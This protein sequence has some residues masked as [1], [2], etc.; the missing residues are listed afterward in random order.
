MI[1]KKIITISLILAW[2]GIFAIIG[3]GLNQHTPSAS[4]APTTTT[5]LS[6]TAKT[7]DL[8]TDGSAV[9]Q[10][11]ATP[12]QSTANQTALTPTGTNS[13]PQTPS[14]TATGTGSTSAT[15]ATSANGATGGTSTGGGTTGGSTGSTGGGTG[16]TGGTTPTPAPSISSFAASPSSVSYNTGSTL[17]WASS[18]ATGCSISPTVGSVAASGSRSTGNLASNTTYTLTCTGNGSASK[19]TTVSVGAP[20]A[21]CGQSGGVCTTAQ[22]ATHNSSSNCWVIYGGYYYIV[23]AYVGQ[24]PSGTSVFNSATCGKDITSYMNGSAST[25]GQRHT[26]SGSSYTILNSYRVGPVQ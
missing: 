4:L 10:S 6:E 11:P 13:T 1:F 9:G 25:A 22:V 12:A 7:T 16:G 8:A 15:S 14:G 17:S 26:H 24:H 20:P 2:L 19:Q 23:T 3:V 18:N 21:S 5:G